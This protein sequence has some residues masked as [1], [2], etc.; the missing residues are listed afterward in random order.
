MQII[1]LSKRWKHHSV[2]AGYDRLLNNIDS[3]DISPVR[4]KHYFIQK[5]YRKYFWNKIYQKSRLLNHYGLSDF[6]T[7]ARVLLRSKLKSTDV[8]HALYAEDQLNLLLQHRE[9]L[10]SALVGSFHL[11]VESA[12]IQNVLPTGIFDR[13]RRLDAA[14]VVSNSMVDHYEKLI[15]AGKVFY[16]PHGIDTEIFCPAEIEKDKH[17][18]KL[19]I[20]IVGGHGRDWKLVEQTIL[21]TKKYGLDISFRAVVPPGVSRRLKLLPNTETFSGIPEKELIDLYRKADAVFLPV[22]FA[23]ANNSLLEALACGTPVISTNIGGIPDYLNEDCGWLLP[24]GNSESIF[25]LLHSVSKNRELAKMKSVP[26]RTSAL[27]FDWE[28][29]AEEIQAVYSTAVQN[30]NSKH[31]R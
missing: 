2:S 24:E 5:K 22:N 26:A 8:V 9:K 17:S 15:G 20:L 28:N 29:I 12:Y 18:E 3:V 21:Q 30:Y 4:R 10:S 1:T 13:F 31:D 19:E 11:P 23:T 27:R 25:E 7:E 16:V 14:I 6:I